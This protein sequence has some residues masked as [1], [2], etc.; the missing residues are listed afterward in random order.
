MSSS[1]VEVLADRLVMG[2]LAELAPLVVPER[3]VPLDESFSP[4]AAAFAAF[5]LEN[6]SAMHGVS[7]G[8][9]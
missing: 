1:S 2:V 6:K 7:G 4:F 9:R 8:V 3:V 5:S